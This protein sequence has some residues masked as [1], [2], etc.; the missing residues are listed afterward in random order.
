MLLMMRAAVVPAPALRSCMTLCCAKDEESE[1]FD[2]LQ[3]RVAKARLTEEWS[4]SILKRKPRFLPFIGAR[5]WASL[6][7]AWLEPGDGP[8][9]LEPSLG[10]SQAIAWLEPD[11]GQTMARRCPGLAIARL[12][13]G[14]GQA[15]P[16]P[17]SSHA[18]TRPGHRLA[19]ALVLSRAPTGFASPWHFLFL[20]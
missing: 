13:P 3:R 11:D 1:A 19:R 10:S 4:A 9:W 14:D 15:W 18:M 8:A 2:S 20:A 5:Q 7:I 17:G 12:E 6:A 16:S